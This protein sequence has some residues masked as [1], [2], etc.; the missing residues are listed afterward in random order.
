[1][2]DACRTRKLLQSGELRVTMSE[3]CENGTAMQVQIYV[4][5]S[6]V[7]EVFQRYGAVTATHSTSLSKVTALLF[8]VQTKDR[9]LVT[10]T[11]PAFLSVFGHFLNHCSMKLSQHC[12]HCLGLRN[13]MAPWL[14]A[15]YSRPWPCNL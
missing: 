9:A 2:A 11:P 7:F 1:M 5:P 15:P 14:S 10:F 13:S 4:R 3:R 8:M 12:Q 6:R